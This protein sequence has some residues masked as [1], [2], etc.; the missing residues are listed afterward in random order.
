MGL[1][2]W[3]LPGAA[4]LQSACAAALTNG[5]PA[6][7]VGPLPGQLPS[8]TN[9]PWEGANAV[10]RCRSFEARLLAY[11][12]LAVQPLDGGTNVGPLLTLRFHCYYSNPKGTAPRTLT[13]P[14]AAY[15]DAP[16]PTDKP[17][18]VRLRGRFADDVRFRLNVA[19]RDNAISVE[20]EIRDPGSL[21]CPSYLRYE[22][23]VPA[24]HSFPRDMSADDRARQLLGCTLVVT[25]ADGR[26]HALP[27][28]AELESRMDLRAAAIRG[29]WGRRVVHIE[30]PAAKDREGEVEVGALRHETRAAPYQGF[31]V[32]RRTVADVPGGR[33]VLT[34]E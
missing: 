22:W 11:S 18:V 19:F 34:V 28:N 23:D 30:A 12:A 31:Q 24:S 16:L 4:L 15:Q 13:R 20:G 17:D 1:W 5:E 25:D 33:L 14:I 8:Y 29:P 21:A 26:E 10:Y 9:G 7:A 2:R 6:V 27:Y 32:G 3:V